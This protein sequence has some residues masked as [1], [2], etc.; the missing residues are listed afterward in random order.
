MTF[1]PQSET[2]GILT[3]S[4]GNVRGG[5]AA[6]GGSGDF[7][8]V[9]TRFAAAPS[10]EDGAKAAAYLVRFRP[11]GAPEGCRVDSPP[12]LSS[13]GVVPWQRTSRT[14]RAIRNLTRLKS[15][16]TGSPNEWLGSTKSTTRILS[17]KQ[18][19]TNPYRSIICLTAAS[20]DLLGAWLSA[21]ALRSP[22]PRQRTP[23]AVLSSNHSSFPAIRTD[24]SA[25]PVGRQ[26]PWPARLRWV[27]PRCSPAP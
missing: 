17:V 3:R 25:F 2:G 20:P 26:L 1:R 18:A 15:K 10:C 22:V 24:V 4:C 27:R 13:G 14:R 21:R 11:G 19:Q 9:W 6:R 5:I 8:M 16:R 12:G 7:S 23:R